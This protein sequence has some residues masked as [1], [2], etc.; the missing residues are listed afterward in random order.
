MAHSGRLVDQALKPLCRR[1]ALACRP[2][3]C[4]DSCPPDTSLSSSEY[5]SQLMHI[6]WKPK[7]T[8][9]SRT[10]RI[11]FN[12]SPFFLLIKTEINPEYFIVLQFGKCSW[13]PK[14][15]KCY[16]RLRCR[17]PQTLPDNKHDFCTYKLNLRCTPFLLFP[18]H[19]KK[20]NSAQ[21]VIHSPAGAVVLAREERNT[22]QSIICSQVYM[23][24]SWYFQFA[25]TSHMDLYNHCLFSSLLMAV[26]KCP[27]TNCWQA[28]S[29]PPSLGKQEMEEGTAG[30]SCTHTGKDQA[31]GF[32]YLY[33]LKEI[34][35]SATTY[36]L[37]TC[38][39]LEYYWDT[40]VSICTTGSDV[41]QGSFGG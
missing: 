39:A 35:W 16:K 29:I 7:K 14:G 6:G 25:Y 27:R 36:Y 30:H 17:W 18:D 24:N 28:V 41:F 9:T 22:T 34:K 1:E 13:K 32:K 21:G 3:S 10:N 8:R 2:A 19:L 23:H 5:K 26:I 11:I 4:E 38:M 15:G 20:K 37:F 40:T 33:K 31:H 12:G